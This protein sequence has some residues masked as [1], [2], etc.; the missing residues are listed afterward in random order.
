MIDD[1]DAIAWLSP[2]DRVPDPG[3]TLPF[4]RATPA[5]AEAREEPAS[6]TTPRRARGARLDLPSLLLGF[7]AGV[8]LS[9]AVCGLVFTVFVALT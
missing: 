2:V 5:T 4:R 3:T 7:S 6:S 8:L 1:D 9:A